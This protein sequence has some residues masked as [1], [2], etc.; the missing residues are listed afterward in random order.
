MPKSTLPN[1]GYLLD[2]TTAQIKRTPIRELS[3]Q[4]LRKLVEC[5][6]LG[7]LSFDAS[8]TLYFDDE[9]LVD[10]LSHYMLLDGHPDPLIGKVFLLANDA[11][12]PAISMADVIAR[13]NLYK[14]VIDPVLKASSTTHADIV[15][16][17]SAIEKFV[18]RIQHHPIEIV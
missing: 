3:A 10:S 8:H 17:I 14:P 2:P 1:T 11:A 4:C 9:G 18:P 16:Y 6:A 7:T 12:A 13:L 15:Y 5:E